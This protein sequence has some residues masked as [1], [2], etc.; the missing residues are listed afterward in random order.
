MQIFGL[1]D[2]ALGPNA[3]IRTPS[4]WAWPAW[5]SVRS[6]SVPRVVI[7]ESGGWRRGGLEGRSGALRGVRQPHYD[8]PKRSGHAK[9]FM[10]AIPGRRLGAA[11]REGRGWPRT[12][13]GGGCTVARPRW[14]SARLEQGLMDWNGWFNCTHPVCTTMVRPGRCCET[15]NVSFL[16]RSAKPIGLGRVA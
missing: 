3:S 4:G 6:V 2:E 14:S 13:V 7:S 11:R 15:C 5:R 12:G 10:G 9:H 16:M 1:G 8:D